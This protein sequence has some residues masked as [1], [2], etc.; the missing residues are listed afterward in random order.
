MT[1]EA[2]ISAFSKISWIIASFPSFTFSPGNSI[3]GINLL[4][5]SITSFLFLLVISISSCFA[6]LFEIVSIFELSYH[7]FSFQQWQFY[8]FTSLESLNSQIACLKFRKPSCFLIICLLYFPLF[9]IR[10]LITDFLKFSSNIVTPPLLSF[11]LLS[12]FY[13][14]VNHMSTD[15]SKCVNLSQPLQVS[16]LGPVRPWWLCRMR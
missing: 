1:F 9:F 13:W 7:L 4:D 6:L 10:I 14:P 15:S 3:L 2:Q 8:L 16:L 12:P 5:C 11:E